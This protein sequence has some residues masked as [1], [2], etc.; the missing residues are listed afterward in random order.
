F[1]PGTPESARRSGTRRR[2]R[3]GRGL[4]RSAGR[5]RRARRPRRRRSPCGPDGDGD[6]ADSAPRAASP[7]PV[8][9]PARTGPPY[10]LPVVAKPALTADEAT[11]AVDGRATRVG[12]AAVADVRSTRPAVLTRSA[13][14]LTLRRAA[15]IASLVFLDLAA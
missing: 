8:Y 9:G 13:L 2:G 7:G 11:P 6:S 1:R 4:R 5:A 3:A 10:N 15:S 14:R 12:P